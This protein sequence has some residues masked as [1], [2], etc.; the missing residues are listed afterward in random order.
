MT[1][2]NNFPD[3]DQLLDGSLDDLADLP[4]FKPFPA[5]AHSATIVSWERKLFDDKADSNK[6]NTAIVVRFKADSTIEPTDPA[7]VVSPGQETEYMYFLAHHSS[8]KAAEIG[9][10]GFKAL[11]ASLVE[12]YGAD[13]P[14]NLMEKS[15]GA[16]VLI[17]TGK[18]ADK[19][20]KSKVYSTLDTLKVL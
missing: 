9:Q 10:G 6:K 13:T 19:K 11:M 18:R 5:G 3:I 17:V 8:P 16:S 4:E 1:D 7:D 12:F 14:R 2:I 15:T 20:D